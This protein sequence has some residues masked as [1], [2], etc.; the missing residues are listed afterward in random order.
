MASNILPSG[1]EMDQYILTFPNELDK[2]VMD[3]LIKDLLGSSTAEANDK[4]LD[5]VLHMLP[6]EQQVPKEFQSLQ[7]QEVAQELQALLQRPEAQE[8]QALLQRQEV[9][10]T[11]M[12]QESLQPLQQ[13]KP[14]EA[15][16]CQQSSAAPTIIIHYV[17]QQYP[18]VSTQPRNQET[19]LSFED[20]LQN[21]E[22][23]IE[24]K[25]QQIKTKKAKK[26]EELQAKRQKIEEEIENDERK[27]EEQRLSKEK[28]IEVI[29]IQ[30]LDKVKNARKLFSG[31]VIF[32]KL[33]LQIN[34]NRANAIFI[35]EEEAMTGEEFV[36][37]LKELKQLA[38]EVDVKRK[39]QHKK[40][41]LKYNMAPIL[42]GIQAAKKGFLRRSLI[43][44]IPVEQLM[45]DWRIATNYHT[46]HQG[47][48]S[49][50]DILTSAAKY[51]PDFIM[52]FINR[53]KSVIKKFTLY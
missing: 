1:T 28:V 31:Q 32:L 42:A 20:L 21:Q 51:H 17:P 53:Y 35:P 23:W 5:E 12:P 43:S 13:A 22:L 44:Q 14:Q 3:E 50:I 40:P 45:K 24:E 49:S 7:P 26:E 48:E 29:L 18:A 39:K 46:Y 38:Q 52:Y 10:V 2:E 34:Q 25:K 8:R 30:H 36:I 9:T 41:A 15:I 11:V 37:A 16:Q 4:L 6:S 19:N 47:L 33:C 27:I